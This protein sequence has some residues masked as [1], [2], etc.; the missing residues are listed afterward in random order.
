MMKLLVV[1]IVMVVGAIVWMN[2]FPS[3]LVNREFCLVVA[4]REVERVQI[5]TIKFRDRESQKEIYD[6]CMDS[7]SKITVLKVLSEW[8]EWNSSEKGE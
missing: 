4:D 5:S 7:H 6:S 1:F 3:S 8:I 2:K